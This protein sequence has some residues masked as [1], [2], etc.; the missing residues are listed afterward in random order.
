ML[1]VKEYAESRS[2]S[3]EAVRRQ[4]IRYENELEDHIIIS[5]RKR[6]LDDEAVAF[7]DQH[8][9]PRNVVI[10]QSDRARKEEIDNLHDEIDRLK[11]ELLIEKERTLMAKDQIIELQKAATVLLEYKAKNQILLEQKDQDQ[12]KL[13]KVRQELTE[14]REELG[15]TKDDL[16]AA[17]TELN[18]FTPSLFGFYRKK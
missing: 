4:L 2:I 7:L 9:M 8:R 5:N 3:Q 10:E 12:E 1:S 15:A 13:E 11:N 18:S 17:Q 6:M 16:A 14:A